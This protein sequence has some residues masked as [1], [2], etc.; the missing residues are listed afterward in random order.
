[1]YTGNK[2]KRIPKKQYKKKI[3]SVNRPVYST[4]VSAYRPR[5]MSAKALMLGTETKFLDCYG[6]V[7]PAS[8]AAMTGYGF[9]PSVGCTGCWSAPAQGSGASTRD[10]NKIVAKTLEINGIVQIPAQTNQTVQD[11][12]GV[13]FIAIV[14][15]TQT[16]GVTL[17]SEQV[18]SNPSA[19]TQLIASG[20]R[21]MAFSSRYVVLKKKIVSLQPQQCTYDGTNIEVAGTQI[22]F[23]MFLNLNDMPVSFSTSIITANVTGVVD[24]SIGIIAACTDN[25]VAPIVYL[26]SRMRFIG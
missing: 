5:S 26:Q 3:K 1:M 17:A 14:V 13:I 18:Y 22:P 9:V 19:T 10:G 6:T 24:N 23:K 8:T 25:S 15:D 7:T 11:T 16:N 21:N 4:A 20:F 2:R 12:S